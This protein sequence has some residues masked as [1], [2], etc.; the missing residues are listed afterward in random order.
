MSTGERQRMQLARA[1]RN[2]TTGVLYILDE[3]S[4]GLHPE[5]LKGL[6]GV[7]QDLI[8]D[9]NS[10]VLVDHDTQVLST[11]DWLIEMGPG[12]GSKG[13]RVI[14]TGTVADTAKRH[15]SK[16]GPFLQKGG[17]HLVLT[18]S[19]DGPAWRAAR[20]GPAHWPRSRLR[21]SRDCR[22]CRLRRPRPD[23]NDPAPRRGSCRR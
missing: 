21:C 16:I 1:V 11:C 8:R 14:G 20:R 10:I 2:R 13:G 6:M 7:M 23:T 9:G 18:C 3:P 12:A 19:P 5:N 22:R 15:T 4:I 17:H